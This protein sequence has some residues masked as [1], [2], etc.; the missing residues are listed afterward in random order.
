MRKRIF[1]YKGTLHHWYS[2]GEVT[3]IVDLSTNVKVA[4]LQSRALLKRVIGYKGDILYATQSGV[5][6]SIIKL[7]L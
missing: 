2:E 3:H 7:G 4:S 6:S 5:N 1:E